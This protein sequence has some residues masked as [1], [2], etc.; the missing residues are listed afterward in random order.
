MVIALIAAEVLAAIVAAAVS[1]FFSLV[2]NL[3][4]DS[5]NDW[6]RG[7]SRDHKKTK[8]HGNNKY[9]GDNRYETGA[10]KYRGRSISASSS[11]VDEY[12]EEGLED[13][14][15]D[16]GVDDL[17]SRAY[18]SSDESKSKGK[19]K[20][21]RKRKEKSKAEL[22][23]RK[24][25]AKKKRARDQELKDRA[26]KNELVDYES[27]AVLEIDIDAGVDIDAEEETTDGTF[28]TARAD[29]VAPIGW[30]YRHNSSDPEWKADLREY[31][32]D[33]RDLCESG[34]AELSDGVTERYRAY[35]WKV[36]KVDPMPISE[37]EVP[38]GFTRSKVTEIGEMNN[39]SVGWILTPT[40]T[41]AMEALMYTDHV[42][43]DQNKY[44]RY[45]TRGS[46]YTI[47]GV[48]RW[49]VRQMPDDTFT[50]KMLRNDGSSYR[51]S[52]VT[53]TVTCRLSD[54]NLCKE[55]DDNTGRYPKDFSEEEI[56]RYDEF[57]KLIDDQ[58]DEDVRQRMTLV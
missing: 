47:Y 50:W 11:M 23:K 22:K 21:K 28:S 2:G 29:S 36:A 48:T 38:P 17:Y 27:E 8:N 3:I 45:G 39:G 30:I 14:Y 10:G 49:D 40:T 20:S 54:Q 25:K 4:V 32:S 9:R 41:Y 31:N 18:S 58:L 57:I 7:M 34:A 51:G 26:E 13:Y 12:F 56:R 37:H 53:D 19:S 16:N 24:K 43:S 46:T 15:D 1:R 42:I 52:G 6:A 5:T 44:N 55:M 35:K 33:L